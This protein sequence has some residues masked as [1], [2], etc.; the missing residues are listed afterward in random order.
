MRLQH[1][2]TQ[3]SH[4]NPQSVLERGYSITYSAQGQLIHNSK[5]IGISDKIQVKFAQGMCEADVTH[6]KHS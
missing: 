6:T 5:Q 4:L 3:L 2:Q 1:L